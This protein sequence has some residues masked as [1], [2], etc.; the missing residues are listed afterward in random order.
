MEVALVVMATM[1]VHFFPVLVYQDQ[2]LYMYRY[3]RKSKTIK[4]CTFTTRLI[5]LNNYLPYFPPLRT[6]QMVTALPDDEV[7]EILYHA[8]PNSWRTKMTEQGYIYLDR[9][10]QKMSV[11]FETRVE[12]L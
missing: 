7:K 9:S 8:I 6:G 1:T 2:K 4:V 5:Q 12:K 3:L 10:I 11:C